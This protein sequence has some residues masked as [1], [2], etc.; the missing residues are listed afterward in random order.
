MRKSTI[1]IGEKY[2]NLTVVERSGSNNRGEAVWKCRCDC[3]GTKDVKSRNLSI[4]KVKSCGCISTGPKSTDIAG[5]KFGRLT[6]IRKIGRD[7]YRGSL[8]EVRCEC[9]T[10]KTVLYRALVSGVVLSCGCYNKDQKA[11]RVGELSPSFNPNRT[12]EERVYGRSIPRYIAWAIAV[13]EEDGFR[14]QVC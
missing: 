5:R 6:A 1:E 10:E 9:G 13:K 11:S 3:G 14:C 7:K 12:E 4:G 2:G 8:W